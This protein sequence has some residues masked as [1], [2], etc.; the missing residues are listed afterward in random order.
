MSTPMTPESPRRT[1]PLNWNK[2]YVNPLAAVAFGAVIIVPGVLWLDF[3]LHWLVVLGVVSAVPLSVV[4]TRLL[5]TQRI[6]CFHDRLEGAGIFGRIVVRLGEHDMRRPDPWMRHA[7]V[8]F[9]I[10]SEAG[11]IFVYR[12]HRFIDLL[13]SLLA[14]RQGV[15]PTSATERSRGAPTR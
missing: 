13:E 7:G 12:S 15:K 3:G 1:F 6:E 14:D 2:H 8:K 9:T 5:T 10:E 4:V 11:R